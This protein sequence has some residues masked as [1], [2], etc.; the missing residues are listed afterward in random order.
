MPEDTDKR[1]GNVVPANDN[2]WPGPEGTE[3]AY[4]DAAP[5]QKLDRVVLSIARLIGRQIARE[6]FKALQAANDNRASPGRA[7]RKHGGDG[8]ND[9]G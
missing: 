3:H 9:A 6:H 7:G 5:R 4:A 8:E 2:H 1:P